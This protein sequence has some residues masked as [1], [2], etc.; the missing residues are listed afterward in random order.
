M[1]LQI[2]KTPSLQK[3]RSM[4]PEMTGP[5][6]DGH[7]MVNGVR[8]AAAGTQHGKGVLRP[9]FVGD[10]LG[11][12]KLVMRPTLLGGLLARIGALPVLPPV[13]PKGRRGP[14][15]KNKGVTA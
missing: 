9:E 8:V 3:I 14:K 2:I 11:A 10:T 5:W 7:Q 12:S 6:D 4:N 1:K 15:P 13:K